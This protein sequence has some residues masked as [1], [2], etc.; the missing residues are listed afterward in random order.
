M[1]STPGVFRLSASDLSNHLACRH[2][3]S[4]DFDVANGQRSAPT[5][6]SPDLWVL[7]K[8]GLEHER[9]YV[10]DLSSEGLSV[11]DLREASE[12]DATS[13]V[14]SV[15]QKGVDVIVQPPFAYG[16]W[17]GRADVLRRVERASKFG[18]WSY[19]AYDCK[20][21]L[22]TKATTILQL[23]LYSECLAPFRANGPNTCTSFRQVTVSYPS[24]TGSLTT[25]R[26]T[27][28]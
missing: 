12:K 3:T 21:A 4:L 20:L 9:A 13:I 23:S 26:T 1:K 19:E 11:V 28:T 10:E 2:L 25:Q 18:S 8:R 17:F 6:F 24:R 22:E 7:Q 16:R 5:W 27:D 14:E 15:M